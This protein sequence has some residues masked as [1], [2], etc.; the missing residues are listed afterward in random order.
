LTPGA[1]T[2]LVQGKNKIVKEVD[3]DNL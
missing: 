3:N 2:K 1:V